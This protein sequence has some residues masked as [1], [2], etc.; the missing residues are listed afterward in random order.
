MSIWPLQLSLKCEPWYS[1]FKLLSLERELCYNFWIH[2]KHWYQ[3]KF[4]N[5][6]YVL[7]KTT[8]L[9]YHNSSYV[10]LSLAFDRYHRMKTDCSLKKK[11][12]PR[13]L[14][15]VLSRKLKSV[16]CFHLSTEKIEIYLLRVLR[17]TVKRWLK[18]LSYNSS[19]S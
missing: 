11:K 2:L 12:I 1:T 6:G 5:D 17:M 15:R 14:F 16:L 10:K 4:R 13:W 8:L 9:I 3:T 18:I 7:F 19:F